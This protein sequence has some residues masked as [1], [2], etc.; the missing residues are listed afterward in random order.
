MRVDQ[1]YTRRYGVQRDIVNH[2]T[3]GGAAVRQNTNLIPK[4]EFAARKVIIL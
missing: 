3:N 4:R 1:W 2:L